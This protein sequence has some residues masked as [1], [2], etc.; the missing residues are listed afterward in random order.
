MKTKN[1]ILLLLILS[2]VFLWKQILAAGGGGGGSVPSCNEDLWNCSD[3]S[4]CSQE[5]IQTR[6]C[7]LSF[8]CGNANT[9]KPQ[10]S[11]SCTPP[12]PPLLP[13]APLP[14]DEPKP[15]PPSC[16][17]DTFTCG[18]WSVSCDSFGRESR[19]C[20][21]SFDCPNA[22]TSPPLSSRTCQK[23]QCGNKETL[24][25]RIYCRLNLAPAGV[26]RE[27]EIQ[28]LPE[29]C[30]GQ[31]GHEQKECVNTYKS[32]QPC[33]NK[34][35]GEERFLCA[36]SALKLGSSISEQTKLCK[37]KVD[38]EQAQCKYELLE[39]VLFMITFRFYDLEIRAET[40]AEK[41]VDLN[42]VADFETIVESKKQG[43]YKA[44]TN[45]ER[46]QIILDVRKAWQDFV[47]EAKSA[48]FELSSI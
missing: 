8:D 34:K 44:K 26:A 46:L 20:K 4:Q 15:A 36:R 18:N 31:A 30:K 5:G 48:G 2:V 17:K 16:A 38:N 40:L 3:W 27:L 39:K 19:V 24:R 37:V 23:L 47:N 41:G 6:T 22:Q 11:Q 35:E 12:V 45:K 42:T 10:E 7:S 14:K 43:F 33:W 9:P 1:L 28:Y 21:L 29:G 32:F 13:P 25:E